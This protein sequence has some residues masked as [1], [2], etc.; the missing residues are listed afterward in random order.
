MSSVQIGANLIMNELSY[1]VFSVD[2]FRAFIVHEFRSN[3]DLSLLL[4]EKSRWEQS[5]PVSKE[6][7]W[8]SGLKTFFVKKLSKADDEERHLVLKVAP[9]IVPNIVKD[10]SRVKNPI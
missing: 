9:N 7:K 4:R 3:E 8:C 6:T 10:L 1:S 2:I 5:S